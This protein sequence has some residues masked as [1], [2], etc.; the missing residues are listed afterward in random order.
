MTCDSPIE[1]SIIKGRLDN[2]GIYCFITNENFSNLMPQFNRILN[3]GAQIMIDESDYQKAVDIL[4]LN[5][6]KE[7]VCPNCKSKSIKLQLGNNWFRKIAVIF[8]SLLSGVPFNNI[9]TT[10]VCK[11]CK[12]EFKNK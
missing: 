3:S 7:L 2:E 10:Y 6:N 5:T 8:M 1:A 11:D 12:T 9:N 4:E